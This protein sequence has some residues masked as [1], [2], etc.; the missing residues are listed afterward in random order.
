MGKILKYCGSCE[1]GFA[2]RFTFCPD[3]GSALQAVEVKPIAAEP[4][5]NQTVEEAPHPSDAPAFIADA[6]I[7]DRLAGPDLS[8]E[9]TSEPFADAD[10]IVVEPEQVSHGVWASEDFG[11]SSLDTNELTDPNVSASSEEETVEPD[12]VEVPVVP[13]APTFKPPVYTTQELDADSVRRASFAD[14][15]N[16]VSRGDDGGYYVTVIQER[17][18]KQRNMLMLGAT[19]FVVFT[20]MVAWMV[21]LFQKE[22]GVASIGDERSIALLID[23]VPMP[24]D[25]EEQNKDQDKGGGGGGGGRDEQ[26]ELSK[27]QL[28]SQTQKPIIN[29]TKTIVQRDNPELAQPI[30]AT[31]GRRQMPRTD[32]QYG[33]PNSRFAGFSDGTGTGGGQGSGFGQGQ[34]SGRGTGMGSGDG[35]GSGSGRGT[36]DGSGRGAGSGTG[37]PP[38]PAAPRVTENYRITSRPRANYTDAARAN[39]V[40]GSVRLRVTLLASGQVGQIVPIT[41]LPHGL[42]EQAIAAARQIQFEPR[43][44]NGQPVTVNVT[45]DYTFNI[46]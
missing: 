20:V 6:A 33:D 11:A 37:A 1:E 22:L 45:I 23:D 31:E 24:I 5:D 38:P 13:P 27:G 10:E 16:N 12:K 18:V 36:G 41:R 43:K 8:T 7:D 9:E 14:K 26:Q 2:E 34:G 40:Q 15:T 35:S 32:E 4:P 3:C 42:T 44:V 30:A 17:N 29:P 21:S 46:Y 25:E 28:A 19:I 39:N